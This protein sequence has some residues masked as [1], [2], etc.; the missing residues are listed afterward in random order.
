MYYSICHKL[1]IKNKFKL[2]FIVLLLIFFRE[3][4]LITYAYEAKE[5][6][7][8]INYLNSNHGQ[9]YILGPGDTLE[10]LFS[11]LEIE[12]NN[13]EQIKKNYKTIKGDGSIFLERFGN[14]Y[15]EGL[16]INELTKL[17]EE[18]YSE[19]LKIPKVEIKIIT[20]RPIKVFIEGEVPNPGLYTLKG[21]YDESDLGIKTVNEIPDPTNFDFSSTIADSFFFP[22]IFDLIRNA[23]GISIYSDLENV[24][25]VRINNLSNGGGK[26]KANINLLDMIENGN[27]LNNIR[28]F[29]GDYIR[30]PRFENPSLGQLSKAMKSNL[31]PKFI[32]VKVSGHVE[33]P[34]LLELTKASTLNDAINYAGG[35]KF[36]SGYINFF[37]INKDGILEKRVIRHSSRNTSGSYKNPFLQSGDMVFVTKGKLKKITDVI[38]ETST[39]V[40]NIYGMY[41]I[42]SD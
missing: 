11:G 21:S 33:Q 23:G 35:L 24:E 37:R 8:N 13:D 16:T 40:L 3:A 31:N 36:A 34:G 10:I 41:K 20:Y 28:L 12:I 1:K 15:I 22:K 32:N 2:I 4:N 38:T 7:L 30:I 17:L 27:S 9:D 39:P 14:I 29:D 18:K 19:Y 5:S 26:I 25:V 42:L 6:S